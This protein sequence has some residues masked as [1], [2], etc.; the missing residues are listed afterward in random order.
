M[1]AVKRRMSLSRR[2][3]EAV[4]AGVALLRKKARRIKLPLRFDERARAGRVRP[5]HRRR[6]AVVAASARRAAP[7]Q[8]ALASAAAAE[9]VSWQGQHFPPAAPP[10]PVP[11]APQPAVPA[12]ARESGGGAEP[13]SLS[14]L[15]EATAASVRAEIV[16]NLAE[17]QRTRIRD[18]ISREL[19]KR[20]KGKFWLRGDFRAALHFNMCTPQMHDALFRGRTPRKTGYRT[21]PRGRHFHYDF[22]SVEELATFLRAPAGS[23][24]R[25]FVVNGCDAVLAVA[26]EWLLEHRDGFTV[27]APLELVWNEKLWTM[28]LFC[29]TVVKDGDGRVRCSADVPPTL[30]QHFETKIISL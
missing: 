10:A 23:L 30:P 22:D 26:R 15:L 28:S 5:H 17:E 12:Q 21:K 9:S 6:R 13:P 16:E 2:F 4:D 7:P 24:Q 8:V 14:S 1:P 11:P 27:R 3:E 18:E 25:S 20:V 19:G 29:H